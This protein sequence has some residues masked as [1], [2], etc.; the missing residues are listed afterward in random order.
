V[1]LF[2]NATKPTRGPDAMRKIH[3]ENTNVYYTANTG[4]YTSCLWTIMHKHGGIKPTR[5]C[6]TH[7]LGLL[8]A[9]TSSVVPCLCL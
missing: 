9:K 1:G 6:S 8:H 5:Q 3:H 2:Y 7:F 4:T